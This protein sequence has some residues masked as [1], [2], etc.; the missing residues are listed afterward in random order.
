M[1]IEARRSSAPTILAVNE[2]VIAS[3]D[4]ARVIQQMAA[5]AETLAHKLNAFRSPQGSP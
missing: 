5:L 4:I 2:A 3:A 1:R